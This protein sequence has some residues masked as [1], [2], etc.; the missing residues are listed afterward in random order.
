[1]LMAIDAGNSTTVVGLFD[2]E[3]LAHHWRL[4]T[5]SRRTPD[6][7]GL[8]L[9]H[10]LLSVDLDPSAD[11]AGLVVGSVVPPVTTTI[12]ATAE[13]YLAVE[14]VVIEPGVRTGLAIHHDDPRMLGA[15]RIANAVAAR[16]LFGGPAIVVDFGTAISFDVVDREQRFIGGAIAPG[17]STAADA[18]VARAA[19][20]PTVEIDVPSDVVGASTVAALRSGI[21]YGFAGLVDG[22]VDRLSRKLGA[23]V[24]TIATGTVPAA[25]LEACSSIDHHDAWLTLKG[26]RLVWEHHCR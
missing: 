24:T 4:S 20:L 6:E 23:G 12:K 14:P 17:I 15:D 9:D 13:R 22:I 16:R 2:G 26:L 18:L 10:M 19:R 21:V 11:L 5:S 3:R 1:M 8:W 25:V 7:F